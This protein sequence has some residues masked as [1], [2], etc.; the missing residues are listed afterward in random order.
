MICCVCAK[1]SVCWTHSPP[2][3]NQ[4]FPNAGEIRLDSQFTYICLI[5]S[6]CILLFH[7]LFLSSLFLNYGNTSFGTNSQAIVSFPRDLCSDP[8]T[9]S[10]SPL[11]SCV[12]EHLVIQA[13]GRFLNCICLKLPHTFLIRYLIY[14]T[15]L[16]LVLCNFII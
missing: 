4:P 16:L 9:L 7:V 2:S 14:S 8:T 5:F 15:H 3:N 11:L 6:T 13:N 10:S 1:G 12:G